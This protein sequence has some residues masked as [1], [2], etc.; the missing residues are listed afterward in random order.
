MNSSPRRR[1]GTCPA[2]LGFIDRRFR[3]CQWPALALL[4]A[5]LLYITGTA[6]GADLVALSTDQQRA[7]GIE[8]AAPER[9]DAALTRRYPAQV[10]VPN[11][12][13]QVVAAPHAG[14]I[15]SLLVAEG[16]RV[17]AGQALARLRSPELV[18]AQSALLES[19]TRLDLANSELARDQMLFK[20]GVIAE[21]RL[22]ESRAHQNEL[23]TLVEQRRQLLELAGLSSADIDALTASRRL[24]SSLPVSAPIGGVVLEQMVSTGQS[25]A[26]AAPLYRIAE[27]NPLW[28]EVHVPVDQLGGFEIGGNVLLPSLGIRGT[29]ITIGRMVHEEDQGVLVRAEV[30]EGAERLRPGQFIE[31][32]VA[33]A[34]QAGNRWRVPSSALLRNAGKAYVFAAREGGFVAMPVKVLAEEE[35]SAVIDGDLGTNDR[36]A[37]SGTVALKAAWLG[38]GDPGTD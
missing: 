21:R 5:M 9:A 23:A 34:T 6:V 38:A 31:V 10:Q 30:S 24:N 29:I 13:L 20:E 15:E 22:L 4:P 27:L 1:A 26:A 11:R 2:P 14:V 35:K 33:A 3:L 28:V 7:F 18:D 25:V 32:Q 37:V 17:A 12:Q 8:L 19:A 36:I 16:E